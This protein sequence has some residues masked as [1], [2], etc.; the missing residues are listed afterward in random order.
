LPSELVFPQF[1]FHLFQFLCK[2]LVLNGRALA[3]WLAFRFRLS[4]ISGDFATIHSL[5]TVGLT[6]EFGA[7]FIFRHSS[8][9]HLSMKPGDCMQTACGYVAKANNAS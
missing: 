7:Q 4:G 2:D 5:V 6:L 3:P 1:F 9:H 8:I